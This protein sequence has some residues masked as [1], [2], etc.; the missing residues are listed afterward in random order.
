MISMWAI[1][2]LY[3]DHIAIMRL[4][5]NDRIIIL[6]QL[7]IRQHSRALSSDSRQKVARKEVV[8]PRGTYWICAAVTT[9][10]LCCMLDTLAPSTQFEEGGWV[11]NYRGLSPG[12]S[13][14][15]YLLPAT[16]TN[17]R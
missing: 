5:T 4:G 8:N 14:G 1:Y 10:K 16:A 17:V 13:P 6:I 9:W 12:I 3:S 15:I 7:I 2:L 11:A